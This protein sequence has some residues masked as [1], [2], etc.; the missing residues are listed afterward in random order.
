MLPFY[1][2]GLFSLII[3]KLQCYLLFTSCN[4]DAYM[5]IFASSFPPF[6]HLLL[7]HFSVFIP[8]RCLLWKRQN[9]FYYLLCILILLSLIW[10]RYECLG[11]VF[12][13][14]SS[15][16]GLVH[17]LKTG[18]QKVSSVH[19][20]EEFEELYLSLCVYL[21]CSYGLP[22]WFS[23]KESTCQCRRP[24]FNLWTRMIPWRRAWLPAP[25]FLPGESY[26]QRNL[27]GCSSWNHRVG[28]D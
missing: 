14:V 20:E 28:H 27:A 24:R 23:G 25:L 5:I 11:P 12:P 6:F 21:T 17:N 9:I 18:Y 2:P 7:H 26:G 4:P 16:E 1:C 19:S 15:P 10:G 3:R 13:S 8:L 22:R